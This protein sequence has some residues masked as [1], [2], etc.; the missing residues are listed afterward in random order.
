MLVLCNRGADRCRHYMVEMQTNGKYVILGEDRAHSSLTDL[1]QYHTQVGIKPFMELLT[2]PC[3]QVSVLHFIK[4]FRNCLV[5]Y[6]EGVWFV[7]LQMCDQ[8]PDYEE[9]KAF[10]SSVESSA[11]CP[12]EEAH[13]DTVTGSNKVHVQMQR[14]FLPPGGN[15]NVE[16]HKPP[17]LKRISDRR[18]RVEAAQMEHKDDDSTHESRPFPRLYP[19]IRLAMRE[20]Q[21][22]QQ[23]HRHRRYG[24]S[25]RFLL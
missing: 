2:V 16:S 1:V 23:V 11:M 19:S 21:Q 5:W 4:G 9:L 18:R 8:E 13:Q 22:I 15:S 14:L 12:A 3:G 10:T 24:D 17:V 6:K 20:I 7:C 25:C